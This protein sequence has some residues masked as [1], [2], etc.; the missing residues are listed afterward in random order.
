MAKVLYRTWP[1]LAEHTKGRKPNDYQI[2]NYKLNYSFRGHDKAPRFELD[3]NAPVV[4]W[5]A[6]YREG[7]RFTVP[8]WD[9]FMDPD[10]T[11][12]WGYNIRQ[13]DA[14]GYLDQVLDQCERDR[15]DLALDPEWLAR[16]RDY[17]GPI[18][19]PYHGLQMMLAYLMQLAPA[20]ATANCFAYSAADELRLVERVAY[21]LT[22]LDF[23]HG[24]MEF[25]RRDRARWEEES[26][27]QPLRKVIER[28]LVTYD[29]GEAF[30]VVSLVLKP[31]LDELILTHFAKMALAHGDA[32]SHDVLRNLHV[33]SLRHRRWST[34]LA[35][36]SIN[37]NSANRDL[38]HGHVVAWRDDV[39]AGI[40]SLRPAFDGSKGATFDVVLRSVQSEHS[41]L[42]AMAGLAAA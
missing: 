19:F 22:M 17:L 27:F 30:A 34:A 12:Y 3:P 36:F 9:G 39:R 23:A 18:R 29:W 24:A 41:T 20:S 1:L 42:L 11:T 28:A 25:G 2:T 26:A 7:S 21:R 40:E 32:A 38:L 33:D 4:R 14:E 13:D 10:E 8:D 15:R 16:V 6:R 5:Y 35:A 37:Q 31:L